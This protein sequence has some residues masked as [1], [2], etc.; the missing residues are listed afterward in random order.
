MS[1]YQ[2]TTQHKREVNTTLLAFTLTLLAFTL[3]GLTSA[4]AM[5]S[6]D[7][8]QD[9]QTGVSYKVYKPSNTLGLKPLNF[10]VRDCK[11]FP[12]KDSYL[13]AGYGGMDQ[14]IALVESSAQFNCAGVDHPQSLGSIKING[15]SAKIGIYCPSKCKASDFSKFGGE[16]TYTTP[17]SK[18]LGSTFIRVGTQGGYTLKELTTFA[19]SLKPVLEK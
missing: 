12:K 16:I 2:L 7:K 3:N 10:E 19:K 14:G 11:L 6:G 1:N 18:T 15:I 8:F 9:L 4:S 13:L 17:K 5:G